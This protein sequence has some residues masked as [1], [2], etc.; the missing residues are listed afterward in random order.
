MKIAHSIKR[1]V[2]KVFGKKPKQVCSSDKLFLSMVMAVDK[3]P[4][5]DGSQIFHQEDLKRLPIVADE[6]S[7]GI[8]QFEVKDALP[9]A[10][11]VADQNDLVLSED[12][13]DMIPF[14]HILV[15]PIVHVIDIIPFGAHRSVPAIS[16]F[17]VP[18]SRWF[19]ARMQVC[20]VFK[21]YSRGRIAVIKI[22]FETIIM[23]V[24]SMCVDINKCLESINWYRLPTYVLRG[25]W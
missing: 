22:L 12:V 20:L 5:F 10:L 18:S 6:K 2:K 7:E 15:L 4:L 21:I 25:P 13:R 11:P 9:I 24:F 14:D 17:S 3:G 1:F 8:E 19:C 23:Y 16:A